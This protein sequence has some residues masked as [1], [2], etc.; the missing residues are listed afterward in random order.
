MQGVDKL[1]AGKEDRFFVGAA[2]GTGLMAQAAERGQADFLLALN[3]GR[4]RSMGLPSISSMLPFAAANEVVVDFVSNELTH[5]T[6][7][8]VFAG[9]CV[10]ESSD[11]LD[12]RLRAIASL[13]LAGV[14]NFPT[15]VHYPESAARTLDAH[16]LGFAAEL[17]LLAHARALGLRVLVYVKTRDQAEMA[18]EIKPDFLCV[19]F[20][21]N[22]G[23]RLTEL[24]PEVSID[25]AILRARDI[26]KVT[27]L[28]SPKTICLI[29]GGPVVNPSQVAEICVESGMRGYIGGSTIDRLPLENAAVDAT[30]AF[31]SAGL[32][33]QRESSERAGLLQRAAAA[34]LHGGSRALTDSL[35]HLKAL[36]DGLGPVVISGETGTQRHA[37]VRFIC[38]EAGHQPD[39]AT[40]LTAD[41]VEP[42]LGMRLF[43]HGD[44]REGLLLECDGQPLLI[45]PLEGLSRRWQRKLG[46]LILN[47]M[48]T[49]FRGHRAVGTRP[50]L[51]LLTEYRL[52]DL[53]ASGHLID[54]LYQL[55]RMREVRMP[56]LEE[57]IE[58]LGEILQGYCAARGFNLRFSESAIGLLQQHNWPGNLPELGAFVDR[59]RATGFSGEV[60]ARMVE[61]LLN[62]ATP[63]VGFGRRKQLAREESEWLL[64]ALRRHAF[65]RT[66][67]ARA[68]GISRKTLYNRMRRLGL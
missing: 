5:P 62:D 68:L 7:L 66:A 56:S 1:L 47:G 38:A 16:G 30:L 46:R 58:S 57:R 49:P 9:L 12:S 59:L 13:G 11:Q 15:T 35:W 24:Q 51:L 17:E 21:W 50:W 14:V 55:L 8:P 32:R 40:L 34:G 43:G 44:G 4:L 31:K 48:V 45:E 36:A 20:G 26:A 67:T 37:A 54:E 3:V 64:A 65:N 39:P 25:E 27:R 19:N 41:Y 60:S 28:R 52:A 18:A 6:R 63:D 22:A 53:A 2:I 10:W 33:R 29:E 23:G 42:Q 61:P